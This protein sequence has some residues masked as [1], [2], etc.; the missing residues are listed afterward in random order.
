MTVKE[1]RQKKQE[2]VFQWYEYYLKELKNAYILGDDLLVQQCY[3]NLFAFMHG[4][5]SADPFNHTW[6]RKFNLRFGE[7]LIENDNLRKGYNQRVKF[8]NRAN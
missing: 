8:Y 7:W 1:K 2:K 5:C 3:S 6:N 4:V